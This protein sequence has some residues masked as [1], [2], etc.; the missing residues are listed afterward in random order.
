M[1]WGEVIQFMLVVRL[2]ADPVRQI[3]MFLLRWRLPRESMRRVYE[4]VERPIAFP[5]VEPDADGDRPGDAE[6]SEIRFEQVSVVLNSGARILRSV[7]GRIRSR[8][9]AAFVGSAG[10]GKSTL[11]QLINREGSPSSGRVTLAGRDASECD[12]LSLA[13]QIGFVP[14]KP[15]LFDTTIRNNILFSLRR[16]AKAPLQDEQGSLDIERLE[17][18]AGLNDLDRELVRVVRMVNLEDDVLGKGL[19]A[20]LSDTGRAHVVR[21]QTVRLRELVARELSSLDEEL[22]VPFDAGRYFTEG[23]VHEN[24]FGPGSRLHVDDALGRGQLRQW[25]AD[26]ALLDDLLS[27]GF[28]RMSRDRA[29]A[30]QVAQ[31]S[32]QLLDLLACRDPTEDASWL[33]SD[34]FNPSL[35]LRENLLSGR[36][37]RRAYR[38]SERVDEVSW[39]RSGPAKP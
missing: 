7:D 17:G 34:H 10:C 25:L 8:E 26:T 15:I 31:R 2:F 3:A 36:P 24:V 28:R 1:T 22:V 37:N 13:R 29:L 20:H 38:S 23:T 27:L 11:L 21:S 39:L 19:D 30:L 14:Q 4:L 35:T 33:A 12:A 5:A 9:H 18:V 16:P 32:S 6:P